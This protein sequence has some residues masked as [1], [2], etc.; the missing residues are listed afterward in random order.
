MHMILHTTDTQGRALHFIL[1]TRKIGM[2]PA[3][4]LC[5]EVGG[6]VLR[7]H[8]RHEELFRLETIQRCI[9]IAYAG[10]HIRALTHCK[11]Q[12]SQILA[13]CGTDGTDGSPRGTI[14]PSFTFI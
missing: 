3:L 12:M 5:R 9:G 8:P 11:V 2:Q 6:A 13:V 7:A 4:N 10:V 14:C 1:Y